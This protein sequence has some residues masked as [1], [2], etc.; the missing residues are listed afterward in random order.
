MSQVNIDH[1]YYIN[2]DNRPDRRSVMEAMFDKYNV[3]AIRFEAITPDDPMVAPYMENATRLKP[4]E[5]ACALSHFEVWKLI[6]SS[7]PGTVACVLEDD[8]RLMTSELC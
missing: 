5:A 7:E 2:L 8:V 3:T 6:A 1:I 4:N